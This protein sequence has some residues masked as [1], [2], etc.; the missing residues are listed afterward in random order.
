MKK[1]D[2]VEYT[3]PKVSRQVIKPTKWLLKL[4]TNYT[5]QT[6][7]LDTCWSCILGS[8][9]N[10]RIS[11][12]LSKR[13]YLLEAVRKLESSYLKNKVWKSWVSKKVFGTVVL[14]NVR[15]V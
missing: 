4:F 5:V 13:K 1:I 11:F 7:C 2:R 14:L 8:Y 15:E 12:N 6:E 3:S 10:F 9:K